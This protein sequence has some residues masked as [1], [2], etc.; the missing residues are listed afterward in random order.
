MEELD[1]PGPPGGDTPHASIVQEIARALAEAATLAD[2]APS[3]LAAVCRT[4]AWEY[5][6]LWE[7]DR[8]GKKLRCVGT[9]HD[10]SLQFTEFLDHSRAI[11]FDRGV[12]LPGRVWASG[13]PAWIPDVVHDSNFPRAASAARVGLHSAVALPIL[14]GADVLGVMEFFSRDV[15]Q[16]D[17]AVL[18][19]MMT[20]GSQIGLYV[21]RKWA[22]DEL[23]AFFTLSPDLLCVASLDGYFLRL[24]P[25]W[26]HVLGFDEA[27]LL[28]AP[29]LDFVHPDD[30]AKTIDAV[31]VLTTG[32][33]LINFENRYRAHDGSYRWLEWTAAPI[34]DQGAIYAAARDVTDRKETDEALKASAENLGQLVKELEVAR[35]KAEAA[36]VA[37]GEFLAN[38]S[39]EIRTPMNAVI[40]MTDLALRTTLT[41]RQRD[42]IQ[43]ANESAEALLAILNDILDASK[44]EA[45]RLALDLVPFG[46]RDTVEDA[47]KMFAPRAN[48]K[49]LELACRIL[50]DVPDALVG[51]PGRLRQVLI[52]LVGNAI[53][54]TNVGD[55]IVEVAADAVNERDAVLRFTVS[56]TG[57]G[58]APEKQW[59]I[60]GAF[61][62][63]DSSTTRQFGGTGLGLTISAQLVEMMGGRIW[64]M[65]EAG[66]GSQFRFV[67]HFG[68]QAHAN[69][70]P[71]PSASTLH[72]LRV[73]VVDDNA[74][75]RT[76]L[77]ELLI[78]WRMQ[79]TAVDSAAAALAAMNDAVRQQRPFH[80]VLT[81]ALMPH[82]DG[83]ML[84]RQ[85]A[86]DARIS[87][88]KVI[89]LTS[90]AAPSHPRSTDRFIA[91]ELTKPVKQSDLL[92][93]ILTAFGEAPAPNRAGARSD[94]SPRETVHRPLNILVA[95]DNATNQKLVVSVL[96][97]QGHRVTTVTTGR[98]AVTRSGEGAF[99]VI[100]MDVQMPEM[101]G[102][103]ATAAI[104]R[105]EAAAGAHTPIVAMTAHAMTGDRE[106]CL[107]AG[108]DAYVS[109]PL[110]HADLLATI[111][112]VFTND[113][114][115][116]VGTRDAEVRNERSVSAL[117]VD[118]S[119]LLA[120]FGNNRTLLAEVI[121]VFLAEMP[122]RLAAV[123][124]GANTR[125]PAA[126]ASAAHALKGSV[127]L[128]SLGAAY[129]AAR[130][131]ELAARAGDLT[132]IETQCADLE[133]EVSLVSADLETLLTTL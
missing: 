130:A 112:R 53:K 122:A 104:R 81:D 105:R 102:F 58:I 43:T 99:D 115:P 6:A 16:A 120:N 118:E 132:A 19:T 91:S 31:S 60:F 113:S 133:R 128:F 110:R 34:V 56:D 67:A 4:L 125:D 100:L 8:A 28:A 45:G 52:N 119:A 116:A 48:E 124:A 35:Q 75:N 41:A 36:A 15:R 17:T 96:E 20:V 77:H 127:G 73:L 38:M 55:V 54:F 108:M 32:A 40:G 70:A 94:R 109:K 95:E 21:A 97:R 7:V 121:A 1:L 27:E 49:R 25:A 44:I 93:A 62:Q 64:V 65:S 47:V 3:M 2:A 84:A 63:A 117:S 106:R 69:V 50:P 87:A 26:K 68:V 61:V 71:S 29:F 88:A 89:M 74:A 11:V 92:D 79:P 22:A 86:G 107:D 85:I 80:L 30:R 13:R 46:L 82:V 131:L 24:N 123:R 12:G 57:I 59:Q 9:W 51:D 5:G 101:D 18:D 76:I 23:E 103:E 129:Q 66:Q 90:G 33:R 114:D 126:L 37:K 10:R 39:H 14:N 83:F 98:E 78:A 42:Y 111:D 72:D